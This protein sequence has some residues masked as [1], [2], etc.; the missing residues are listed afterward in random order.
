MNDLYIMQL[1]KTSGRLDEY[2]PDVILVNQF[3]LLLMVLDH[4]EYI[5]PVCILHHYTI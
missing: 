5:S 1:L 3:V 2:F 4:L